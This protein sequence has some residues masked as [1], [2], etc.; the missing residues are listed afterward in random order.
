M[1]DLNGLIS[2]LASHQRLLVLTGAGLS[3]ASGIPDYRDASGAWKRQQPVQYNDFVSSAGVRR[4]Y[5]G[6]S[7]IGWRH[8]HRARPNGAHRALVALERLERT[9]QLVTQ[10]VDRLHQQ[11]GSRAVIDLHGRIDRVICLDCGQHVSRAA[12]QGRLSALNPG[13]EHHSADR[14]PDGD[15]DLQQAD[16]SAFQVPACRRCGGVMKPDVVFFG[17]A[18]PKTRSAAAM[19]HLAAADALLVVG[20]SLMVFS[21]YRFA[22][23]AARQ[24]KPIAAINLGMTRADELLALKVAAP[25]DQVLPAAVRELSAIA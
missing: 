9:E 8:M 12:F 20:S 22:R 7:L 23:E 21:G 17:E 13:W 25:C 24:G 4:R 18:V 15:A 2:F 14:A 6:R 1:A 16:F 11:A 3:T 5:W 19:T 10:N